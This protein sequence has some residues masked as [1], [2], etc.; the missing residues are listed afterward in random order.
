M[1]VNLLHAVT[2]RWQPPQVITGKLT[3]YELMMN[4]R[5][6]YSGL[7]DNY[8]VNLLKPDTEYSFVVGIL[9]FLSF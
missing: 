8:Q 4:G 3:R 2:V 6:V 7:A 5:C 1:A 9:K